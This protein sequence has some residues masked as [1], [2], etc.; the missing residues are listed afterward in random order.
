[1]SMNA[2]KAPEVITEQQVWMAVYLEVLKLHSVPAIRHPDVGH[3]Q[4]WVAACAEEHARKAVEAFREARPLAT[5]PSA[6]Q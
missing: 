6:T 2:D 4:A 1:M 3:S 5:T